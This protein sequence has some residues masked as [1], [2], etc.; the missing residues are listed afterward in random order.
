MP[1]ISIFLTGAT[2]K[3]VKLLTPFT[4]CRKANR[5]GVGY[6]G[7]SVLERLL[8]HPRAAAFKIKALVRSPDKAT[9]LNNIGVETILGSHSDLARIKKTASK[10]DVVFA[11]VRSIKSQP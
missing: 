3:N 2:G 1:K 7:G 8:L 10:S 5:F 9:K 4:I 11:C 6:I